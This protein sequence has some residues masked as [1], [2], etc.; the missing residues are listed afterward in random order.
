MILVVGGTGQLG[1]RVVR[2]LRDR[3]E[4]VRCLVRAGSDDA[5]LRAVGAEIV[6]GDLIDPAT[7]PGAC[8]GV[9]TVVATATAITGRLAGARHP[10][11]VEVDGRGMAALVGA[12]ARAGVERFVYLSFAGAESGLG[13][14]MERAKLAI[15]RRL[16]ASQLRAVIVR[17]DAYQD[18]HLAPLGRF[19]VAGGKAAVI[20]RGDTRR[21]PVAVDDVAALV[22]AVALEPDPPEV[23][24]FGGPEAISR[25]QAI[26]VAERATGRPMKRRR[27]PAVAARLGMRLLARRNDALASVF[28]AGLHQDRVEARWDDGPLRERGIAGRSATQFIQEQALG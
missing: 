15:E 1:G 22:A 10:S 8:E 21:R 5:P 4:K 13:S 28:A 17:P 16:R 24:E 7:L 3:G 19:D 14:P 6:Q 27:T 2:L 25:N 23:V 12:A 18:I 20:G 11:I 26:A 9:A